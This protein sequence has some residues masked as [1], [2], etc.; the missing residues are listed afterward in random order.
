VRRARRQ[1]IIDVAAELF[2]ERGFYGVTVDEIGAALGLSGPALYHH[3]ASKEELLGEMLV[4][5]SQHLRDG[6]QARVEST[7]EPE[8]ALEALLLF[9]IDFS[10]HQSELIT[11]HFRDLVHAPAFSRQL[12]RRLQGEYVEQWVGVLTDLYPWLDRRSARAT[13][14]AVL[15]LLNSTPYS[16]RIGREGM[17][18]L[19]LRMS[20][21]AIRSTLLVRP[22][23]NE[24][25]AD[26][27]APTAL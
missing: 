7:A 22:V 3:F 11:V 4:A 21:A 13:T 17:R 27:P 8:E 18:E 23:T 1:Q 9:H 26:R 20:H 16:S 14:H 2:A 15:G 6:G 12:V 25:T 19:L 24:L 10:L 5:I